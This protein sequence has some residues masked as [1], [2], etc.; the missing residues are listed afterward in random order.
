VDV[1]SH[2]EVRSWLTIL[3]AKLVDMKELV[4][5][6]ALLEYRNAAGRKMQGC[7][8]LLQLPLLVVHKPE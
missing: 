7:K 3:V 4:A 5:L 6:T 2:G 8:A 1:V